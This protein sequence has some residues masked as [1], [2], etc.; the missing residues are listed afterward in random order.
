M[1]A[2]GI[3]RSPVAA[4]AVRAASWHWREYA[5]EAALLGGFMVSACLFTVVLFHPAS[6]V[7]ALVTDPLLRR[8]VMGLAMGGT[9]VA[10]IYSPWGKRSGAHF[11]PAVTLTFARLG[12]VAPRD[13]GAYVAAQFAGGI[14][15]VLAAKALAGGLL[16]HRSVR[17][18]ATVPGPG[19]TGLAFAAEVAISFVLMTVVLAFSSDPRRGRYTG[20]AA[21]LLVALFI[22]FESPVSGM[23]M[24]PAR[25]VGSAVWAGTWTS[26]WIYFAAPLLGML[27][28]AEADLRRRGR[29]PDACAKLNHQIPEPC[30]FCEYR[31][32]RGTSRARAAL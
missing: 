20:L 16:A 7:A 21:G 12:R 30:I 2:A 1:S 24:N 13:A 14:L 15:G 10:L 11:N 31:R 25:T 32:T 6:P 4:P 19:G 26:L 23:S 3:E 22:T 17:Y 18:A 9:A 5:I 28:A 8:V 27:G 29:Q